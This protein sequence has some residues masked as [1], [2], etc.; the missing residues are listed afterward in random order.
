[1]APAR[2][3]GYLGGKR[4]CGSREPDKPRLD[5]KGSGP[6]SG[7]ASLVAAPEATKGRSGHDTDSDCLHSKLAHLWGTCR[8]RPIAVLRKEMQEEMG[9]HNLHASIVFSRPFTIRLVGQKALKCA[10]SH[11]VTLYR[12][13][14]FFCTKMSKIKAT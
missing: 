7:R 11:M 13:G 14:W 10:S 8:Y 9:S 6:A 2:S 12:F 4:A 1:M 5:E 3:H